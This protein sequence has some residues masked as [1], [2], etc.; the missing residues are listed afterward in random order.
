MQLSGGGIRPLISAELPA[1]V[2]DGVAADAAIDRSCKRFFSS[3]TNCS[4]FP[5]ALDREVPFPLSVD[6]LK[7]RRL[8]ADALCTCDVSSSSTSSFVNATACGTSPFCDAVAPTLIDN[9]LRRAI[10]LGANRFLTA[11]FWR[12]TLLGKAERF[13]LRYAL[14]L[15]NV[16]TSKTTIPVKRIASI[17]NTI[18]PILAAFGASLG[19]WLKYVLGRDSG[20]KKLHWNKSLV[21]WIGLLKMYLDKVKLILWSLGEFT[22]TTDMVYFIINFL[23]E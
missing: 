3:F 17:V 19:G 16:I 8:A 11:R 22:S 23:D 6:E 2:A 21:E 12:E 7:S 13:R 20:R 14:R 10:R 15:C 4:L 18:A 1:A 5:S 9:A